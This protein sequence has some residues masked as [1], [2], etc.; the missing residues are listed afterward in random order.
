MNKETLKLVIDTAFQFIESKESGLVL[1]ITRVVHNAII[2]N[3]D[4]ILDL[5]N[6]KTKLPGQTG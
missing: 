5:V 2:G 3:L 4:A 6:K 1:I